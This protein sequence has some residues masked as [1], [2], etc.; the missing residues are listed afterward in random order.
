MNFFDDT[1]KGQ[2]KLITPDYNQAIEHYNQQRSNVAQNPWDV[3]KGSVWSM[4]SSAGEDFG[5][6]AWP[7]A[8][9]FRDANP[10]WGAISELAGFFVPIGG[11]AKATAKTAKIAGAAAKG[12]KAATRV[13]KFGNFVRKATRK[14]A[15][16]KPLLGEAAEEML[17]WGIFEGGRAASRMVQGE[18]PGE[19]ISNAVLNIASEGAGSMLFG[20]LF[21][22]A[23]KLKKME[24]D[25]KQAEIL[26]DPSYATPAIRELR[27]HKKA[28]EE[29]G[30]V[31]A[32]ATIENQIKKLRRVAFDETRGMQELDSLVL[33]AKS[34]QNV[35]AS[36]SDAYVKP[37]LAVYGKGG[38]PSA[39]GAFSPAKAPRKQQVRSFVADGF[40]TDTQFERAGNPQRRAIS[41]KKLITKPGELKPGEYDRMLK[42]T[43]LTDEVLDYA[44]MPRYV[45]TN[46]ED[47]YQSM[48][49]YTKHLDDNT[50]YV[51]EE[52]GL[53]IIYKRGKLTKAEKEILAL[54]KDIAKMKKGTVEKARAIEVVQDMRKKA[55][56]NAP[57][58]SYASDVERSWVQFKT[59]DV[60][61]FTSAGQI[62]AKVD[63][64][65]QWE[66]QA[67]SKVMDKSPTL[68][69]L[70]N[71]LMNKDY[72]DFLK[73]AQDS[74]FD[75]TT[76]EGSLKALASW[77]KI[78][79]RDATLM[80]GI[81]RVVENYG[82]PAAFQLQGGLVPKR[83]L[84]LATTAQDLI[85]SRT[86]RLM[87]KDLKLKEDKEGKIRLWDMLTMQV[88]EGEGSIGA[89]AAKIE[90]ATQAD[91]E[92]IGLWWQFAEI[93]EKGIPF[94]AD[95][96]KMREVVQTKAGFELDENVHELLG[97]LQRVDN[98]LNEEDRLL[99]NF[100]GES[101][102]YR[103]GHYLAPHEWEGDFAVEIRNRE[104]HL[105]DLRAFETRKE[106]QALRDDLQVTFDKRKVDMTADIKDNFS[107]RPEDIVNY[108]QKKNDGI[109]REALADRDIY[110]KIWSDY[111]RD[112]FDPKTRKA[113]KGVEGY[114]KQYTFKDFIYRTNRHVKS[115]VQ[116]ITSKAL[117]QLTNPYMAAFEATGN[118]VAQEVIGNR[119]KQ[120]EGK[121]GDFSKAV[122]K[123]FDKVLSPWLGK[124]SATKIV[125]GLNKYTMHAM[126][127][128]MNISYSSLAALT[129]LQ[130]AMGEISYV[131]NAP[132][133]K[134]ANR[135]Q[136]LPITKGGKVVGS[137][138]VLSPFK[139][140]L[141]AWKRTCN[142]DD[143]MKQI[144]TRAI[145]DGRVDHI[146]EM[147]AGGKSVAQK[148]QKGEG[149]VG[150]FLNSLVG[151]SELGMSAPERLSRYH[152]LAM[153]TMMAQD[154]LGLKN[155]DDIYTFA[156]K[157]SDNTMYRYTQ[158]DKP[159]AFAGP[160][161]SFFGLFKN[162]A[163]HY[164]LNSWDYVKL[165]G[166]GI[167]EG[168]VAYMKPLMA[169]MMGTMA[170]GGVSATP[171]YH[172]GNAVYGMFNDESLMEGIYDAL[173]F[174]TDQPTFLADAAVFGLPTLLGASMTGAVQMVNPMKDASQV[175]NFVNLQRFEAI[176]NIVQKA[177]GFITATGDPNIF[178]S[179]QVRDAIFQAIGPKTLTRSIQAF[180]GEGI[181][182][183][184]SGYP[185]ITEA[186]IWQKIVYNF[187]FTPTELSRVF[188]MNEDAW[189]S[190]KRN[191]ELVSTYGRYMAEAES[192]GDYDMYNDI[193]RQALF[194]GVDISS[195]MASSKSFRAKRE[196]GLYERTAP[197]GHSSLFSTMYGQ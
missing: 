101:P 179:P 197:K 146:E 186:D 123:V 128:A 158:V 84:S 143:I 79:D 157:F 187:G 6:P 65:L 155:V 118:K 140:G 107:E 196:V 139:I 103:E 163:A 86:N 115:R 174:G 113:R 95:L 138:G 32:A 46:S 175:V 39:R 88:E 71:Q 177:G 108:M 78:D 147:F 173:D 76:Q 184:K 154:Y 48:L 21:G 3:L 73:W 111:I 104:G 41:S 132:I 134:L 98:I 68:K 83:V 130:T 192:L 99:S 66:T 42:H 38:T 9:E 11:W 172:A 5:F 92:G 166:Q 135:Y 153:G 19:A 15:D 63:N 44:Q 168:K 16:T 30:N 144:Y 145:N 133:A 31:Q 188:A 112:Y 25:L 129:F 102:S 49:D 58:S 64:L 119:I 77:M 190:M 117:R 114:M 70:I 56:I 165:A 181:K 29:I 170:L 180:A 85:N 116:S 91:E 67:F 141:A 22:G 8:R 93:R 23:D 53:A 17:R 171:L 35:K 18:A 185:M 176:Q 160:V 13:T 54:E 52:D 161:G 124:D 94:E 126:L 182:S 195:V 51:L 82:L 20:R 36:F 127:G 75:V 62:S 109:P 24:I 152:A 142:P 191:R 12:T 10:A 4:L 60:D 7:G 2:P 40:Y 169:Q 45:S 178:K 72:T 193:Y 136:Y 164:T 167:K 96:G 33:D 80:G 34:S 183:M 47:V 37:E 69:T 120:V 74:T 194:S 59:A 61:K 100:I 110:D 148:Y 50:R 87:Y 90:K 81:G 89:L 57:V 162:W 159:Y 122:N 150:G 27:E 125:R 1:K 131:F 121:A 97:E 137:M 189:N 151:L 156:S 43:G 26:V 105:V 106:A 14:L 28:M 55:G 149:V